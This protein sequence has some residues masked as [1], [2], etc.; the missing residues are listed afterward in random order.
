MP[1]VLVCG[2]SGSGK[3]T[4]ASK[5]G[6]LL[7]LTPVVLDAYF[8]QPGWV[9]SNHADFCARVAPVIEQEE[10]I[11]DGNYFNSLGDLHLTRATHVFYF[12]LSTL[13]CMT[14]VLGRTLR[15]YGKTRPEMAPGCPERFDVAFLEYVWAYRKKHRPRILQRFATL[16][17]EQK[18]VMFQSRLEAD[19]ALARI[20]REGLS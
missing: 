14:S 15:G 12:D 2:C 3:S 1:R 16:R 7:G 8:W 9:E 18:L 6:R 19:K 4:F 13:R 10:W 11:L 20:A 5:L 17:P